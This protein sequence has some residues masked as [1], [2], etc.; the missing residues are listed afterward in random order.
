MPVTMRKVR[1]K[2]RVCEKGTGRI[3]KTKLGNPVDGGGMNRARVGAQVGHINDAWR[4]KHMGIT[5]RG[6]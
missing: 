5:G 1:G 3:A 6:R 2:Y 4:E